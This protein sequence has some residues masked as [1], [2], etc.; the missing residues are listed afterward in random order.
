MY[1]YKITN[2][3]SGSVYI[4]ITR[5]AVSQRFSA[6]K[7]AA[8]RGTKN[9]K[10]YDAMRKYGVNNFKIE[11]LNSYSTEEQLLRAERN[12]IKSFRKS[13]YRDYN[14]LDG[15]TSYFP[16]KDKEEWLRKM[17]VGRIGKTPALGMKHTEENKKLF[18]KV[19]REYWD[20]QYTYDRSEII[21]LSFKEAKLK[22]GISKTHYYRI[23]NLSKE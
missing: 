23:R 20:S 3:I 16:I 22:F 4:G 2:I 10:L 12:A 11:I 15:G 7:S 8:K 17:K 6:H 21:K 9:S 1:L 19:S 5:R 14:I 13:G 18:S